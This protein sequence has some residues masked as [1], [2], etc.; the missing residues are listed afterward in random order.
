[1]LTTDNG[2]TDIT[3]DRSHDPTTGRWATVPIT[4]S[5]ARPFDTTY[6]YA[7]NRPT[8]FIDPLGDRQCGAFIPPFCA[9]GDAVEAA[10][11]GGKAARC[12]RTYTVPSAV[13][14]TVG[15]L[16]MDSRQANPADS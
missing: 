8:L 14:C 4:P 5:M 1:M 10:G 3:R 6:G 15:L 16:R 13:S 7:G 2:S 11:Q 12:E 9:V